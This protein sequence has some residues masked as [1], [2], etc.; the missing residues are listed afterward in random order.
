MIILILLLLLS[1]LFF[2]LSEDIS[3][4]AIIPYVLQHQRGKGLGPRPSCSARRTCRRVSSHAT[5]FLG[6]SG[7]YGNI[8]PMDKEIH[9]YI[10]MYIYVYTHICI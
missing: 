3:V 2:L 6:V 4:I 5:W 9:E 10:Y 1:L 8:I 7:E